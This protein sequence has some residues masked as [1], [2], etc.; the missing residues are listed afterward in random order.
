[1]VRIHA[2][3]IFCPIISLTFFS[4]TSLQ[5]GQH[6]WGYLHPQSEWEASDIIALLPTTL[7]RRRKEGKV[8]NHALHIFYLIISQTNFN[9]FNFIIAGR[10]AQYGDISAPRMNGNPSTQS[11]CC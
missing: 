6:N 2:L 8:Q 4:I 5:G 9:F 7:P 3:H 11:I 10:S 1:M